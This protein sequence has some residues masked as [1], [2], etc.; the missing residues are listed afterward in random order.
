MWEKLDVS[1]KDAEKV[2]RPSL[3]Y[4]QDA[5][6]RLKRNKVAIA[7]LVII[8]LIILTSIFVPFFWK[9][10][11]SDQILDFSNIPPSFTI[12]DLGDGNYIHIKSEYKVIEVTK[13]GKLLKMA[14]LINEDANN[15]TREYNV[16]GN[17]ILVD[18]NIGYNANKELIELRIKA[19]RDS[20]IDIK[21][22]EK[23][24]QNSPKYKVYQ[25]DS[26]LTENFKVRNKDYILGTDSLGR[27]LFIRVIYG[28][29]ISLT[30][31]II[32]AI[33]N[34]V[35]GVSYGAISGYV[36]GRVDDIMMRIVDTI[37]AIPLMLYVILLSVAMDSDGGLLT[38]IIVISAVYWL[39][40]ARLV[41]GQ[42]LSLKE[43]EFILAAQALGAS[44]NRI[45][46]RHLVPNIMG[47][48]MVSITM[49][50]PSAIFTEA[51]LSFIGLGVSAP[52]ASWGKLCNDA[53]SSFLTFPY[54]LFYP[55]LAISITILAFNLLGDGLRD[56]LDPKLRK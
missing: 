6:L 11:Y 26:E 42:V 12:Y 2:E 53:L 44:S 20:S 52:M 38:I 8:I 10:K 34:F 4:W 29:R 3:T 1:L 56:A 22:L 35:I 48:V 49:Q 46:T 55:A 30:V 31:G 54:Q 17:H 7:S 27:D 45:I 41:R 23:E 36:G 50:I 28:A 16:G 40:M 9:Y 15:R 32:A 24:F 33:M 13:D 43:Q 19:R 39:G 25:N 47:P 5:W 21:K 37:S 18:Y 14:E 51:F